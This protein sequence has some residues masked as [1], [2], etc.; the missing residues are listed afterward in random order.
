MAV[1]GRGLLDLGKVQKEFAES[2]GPLRAERVGTRESLVVLN[3][4]NQRLSKSSAREK[5]NHG[6]VR[7][8]FPLLSEWQCLPWADFAYSPLSAFLHVFQIFF[9]GLA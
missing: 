4:S 6:T 7:S 9:C 8:F 1:G 3:C 2:K 5:I